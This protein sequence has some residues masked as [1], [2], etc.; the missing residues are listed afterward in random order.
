[1]KPRPAASA[2]QGLIPLSAAAVRLLPRLLRA[3]KFKMALHHATKL[4]MAPLLLLRL[5][6]SRAPPSLSSLPASLQSRSNRWLVALVR[7][8]LLRSQPLLSVPPPVT[9]W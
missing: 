5:A 9:R 6:A 2:I 4:K 7:P 1:V 3:T 8:C